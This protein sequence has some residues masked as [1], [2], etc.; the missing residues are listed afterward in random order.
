VPEPDSLKRLYF[1]WNQ[2]LCVNIFI[3]NA[4]VS[5][6][7][8]KRSKTAALSDIDSENQ[9]KIRDSQRV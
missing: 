9:G 8:P 7:E 4:E 1:H 6:I 3:M 2:I 5:P